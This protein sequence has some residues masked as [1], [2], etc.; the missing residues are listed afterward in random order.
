MREAM[1]RHCTICGIET[2][3]WPS[4]YRTRSHRVRRVL[5]EAEAEIRPIRALLLPLARRIRRD[6][7]VRITV[8]AWAKRPV[9]GDSVLLTDAVS[10]SM[11]GIERPSPVGPWSA[12]A[13]TMEGFTSDT[14]SER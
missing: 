3:N 7:W 5:A 9:S 8:S 14:R 1:K 13:W 12:K 6:A 4:H 10:L 2:D 11:E